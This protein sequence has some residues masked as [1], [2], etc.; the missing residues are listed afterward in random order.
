MKSFIRQKPGKAQ[1]S[2]VAG[3]A[4][5][6]AS[7]ELLRT[8][9]SVFTTV[10]IAGIF[11][12]SLLTDAFFLIQTLIIRFS[13]RLRRSINMTFIP[14]YME[15]RLTGNQ[16]D[17]VRMT[18][19][20]VSRTLLYFLFCMIIFILSSPYWVKL[21]AGDVT[22]QFANA[23]VKIVYILTPCFL[24]TGL[25]SISE[26]ICWSNKNYWVPSLSTLVAA[27]C[28]LLSII[29]L[30][31]YLGI[32]GIAIFTTIGIFLAFLLVFYQLKRETLHFSFTIH[33]K[34][35]GAKRIISSLSP[36]ILVHILLQLS[37]LFD[38]IFALQL[39][40][41]LSSTLT[42]AF[43]ISILIPPLLATSLYSSLLP[44]VSE[45]YINR[46]FVSFSQYCLDGLK[47]LSYLIIPFS[48]LLI[49]FGDSIIQLVF[50]HGKFDASASEQT[51]VALRYYAMGMPA[52]CLWV[53]ML[54]IYMSFGRVN[55][56]LYASMFFVVVSVIGNY[57]FM[58][59][60]GYRGLPLA[61]SVLFTIQCVYFFI[62]VKREFSMPLK[63]FFTFLMKVCLAGILMGIAVLI[64]DEYVLIGLR[65]RSF[66]GILLEVVSC[67]LFGVIIYLILAKLFRIRLPFYNF[68]IFKNY[69][70]GR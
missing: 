4:V 41:G 19:A 32:Y 45:T 48:I 2:D 25:F 34:N 49:I 29:L 23:A 40:E 65:T 12:A 24:F 61:V 16:G 46:D 58:T 63:S 42:Y 33:T 57:I 55:L 28:P 54:G 47:L 18:N 11:G 51:K 60:F 64:I 37:I 15:Y 31:R 39:G 68:K 1:H 38:K 17:L 50:E 21:I 3:T 56:L 69:K 44:K 35:S 26:S 10:L 14:V 9:I 7:V 66:L 22:E 30:H 6:L 36:I 13:E 27:L 62:L 59:F 20:F 43:S 67:S 8:F 52:N 70:L 53:F 5:L